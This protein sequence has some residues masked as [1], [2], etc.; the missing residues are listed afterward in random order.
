MGYKI[1]FIENILNEVIDQRLRENV[2]EMMNHLISMKIVWD[3]LLS[4]HISM[5]YTQRLLDG[6]LNHFAEG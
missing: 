5:F 2:K 3:G 6:E 1:N 4:F